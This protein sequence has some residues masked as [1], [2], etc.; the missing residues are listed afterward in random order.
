MHFEKKFGDGRHIAPVEEANYAYPRRAGTITALRK[1]LDNKDYQFLIIVF[2]KGP[3]IVSRRD[4]F[5]LEDPSGQISSFL[6][7]HQ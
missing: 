1:G 2:L 7:R 6:P 5:R 4:M 3:P